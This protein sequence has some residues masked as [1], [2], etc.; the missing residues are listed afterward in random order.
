MGNASRGEEAGKHFEL[1]LRYKAGGNTD[2][3]L[4]Q[5]NRAILLD[6]AMFVFKQ[7]R[8]SVY[9]EKGDHQKALADLCAIPKQART[10][11]V[12]KYG[13]QIFEKLNLPVMAE[14]W[15]RKATK[16]SEPGD[17]EAAFAFQRIRV[18]RLYDP[19]TADF[20]VEVDF[21]QFGRAIFATEDI[22]KSELCFSDNAAVVS[23]IFVKREVKVKGCHHC[24]MSML[25]AE[26]YFG[27][28]L[29]EM[30]EGLKTFVNDHWPRV[31][32]VTCKRCHREI[33]CS[34]ACRDE[35]WE[36]YHQVICP[37]L[38]PER[39]K[40]Y[41]IA[42]KQG[43]FQDSDGDWSEPWDG[44]YSSLV[45]VQ[46]WAAI[47]VQVKKLMKEKQLSSP[48]TEIWAVAKAPFRR[49]IAYGSLD[50]AKR[51]SSMVDLFK[52]MF[53][54]CGDGVSYDITNAEFNGRYYQAT[55]NLQS[56][57]SYVTPYH[58]FL[59]RLPETEDIRAFRLLKYVSKRCPDAPFA[60][61]FPLQCCLNH[62]CDNNV[63]VSDGRGPNGR[64]G[65]R[66]TAKRD[67][68]KGEELFT[69]YIDTTMP[70]RLRRAW[71]YK[72]FN[73]WC[74]CQ[75]CQFEGDDSSSCTNCGAKADEGRRFPGCG[76]CHKAWYCS[77]A[78]QKK[79]WKLSHKAICTQPHSEILNEVGVN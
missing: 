23:E 34:D 71:L 17:D 32:P 35:A 44:H 38:S 12:W 69:T 40:L 49:F 21:R 31:D 46:I 25:T 53:A 1:A 37:S 70:R 13:G 6:P 78:C 19:L 8:G 51:M 61:L 72:S 74:Q 68:K 16:L 39:S 18:H 43:Y 54:D 62:S 60:G 67:I 42:D 41:D 24:V 9:V 57:G 55:C 11:D 66:V 20:P 63:E 64:P 10:K 77:V 76:K 47:V 52:K 59:D 65:V 28:D 75:R 3:C 48:T 26:Q 4:E 2:A 27:K 30:E 50:A 45:L 22:H 7:L 29:E 58:Q 79:A 73:F 33:Y 15:F 56:F 5:C 14:F 36:M